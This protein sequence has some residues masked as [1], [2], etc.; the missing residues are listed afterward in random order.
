MSLIISFVLLIGIAVTI[1]S[2]AII[3]TKNLA[4]KQIE[5]TVQFVETGLECDSIYMNVKALQAAECPSAIEC[6]NVSNNGFK[7]VQR[8]V[9]RYTKNDESTN[10]SDFKE[11]IRPNTAKTLNTAVS[12]IDIKAVEFIPVVYAGNK[13]VGCIGKKIIVG[14]EYLP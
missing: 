2:L 3:W 1:S 10:N 12:F 6:F 7:T 11:E 14:E 9:I 13:Y 5:T 4:K 8:L